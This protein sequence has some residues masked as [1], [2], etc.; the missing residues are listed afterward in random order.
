MTAFKTL[1]FGQ[2]GPDALIC[3]VSNATE[4]YYVVVT[5]LQRREQLNAAAV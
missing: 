2:Q 1:D 4:M 3:R 5:T